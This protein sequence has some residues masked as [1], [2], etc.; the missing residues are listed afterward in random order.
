MSSALKYSNWLVT[1]ILFG[2]GSRVLFVIVRA[3]F[4]SGMPSMEKGAV[5]FLQATMVALFIVASV[6][7][8]QWETWGRSLG[9]VICAWNAFGT[10]LFA[11]P[12]P[13]HRFA[14]LSL[15]V[16]MAVI[17]TWFYLR[18][19]K[20][21]FASGKLR[22]PPKLPRMNGPLNIPDD[23]RAGSYSCL[24]LKPLII[25][26]A[27]LVVLAAIFF[28]KLHHDPTYRLCTTNRD[29]TAI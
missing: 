2:F 15:C 28:P 23:K 13:K 12:G 25:V 1:A 16:M 22:F 26:G 3:L 17:T 21:Q 14:I 8:A 11:H 9:I 18:P 7:T 6:G 19:V 10:F 27:V 29:L 24:L 5:Y 4:H 20:V